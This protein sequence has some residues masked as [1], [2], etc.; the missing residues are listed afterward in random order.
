M[1]ALARKRKQGDF[2][3]KA[4]PILDHDPGN[5]LLPLLTKID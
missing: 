1:D 5:P 4:A 2:A 3:E